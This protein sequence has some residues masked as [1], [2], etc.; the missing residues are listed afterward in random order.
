MGGFDSD[1]DSGRG[2]A[3]PA[4]GAAVAG[5]PVGSGGGQPGSV[6]PGIAPSA[7]I[8]LTPEDQRK[9]SV[10]TEILTTKNDND[11]RMDTELKNLSPAAKTAIQKKYQETVSEKRNERGTL[12]FVL[13]REIKDAS[14]LGFF[15]EVL[16]EKACL[17][18]ENCEKPPG[19]HSGEEEHLEAINETTANYPQLMAVR[20]LVHRANE[21]V[22]T[23][24][25]GSPLYQ[26]ILD[27]LKAAQ[28]SPNPKVV[29]LSAQALNDLKRE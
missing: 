7:A 4:T 11:P 1:F 20:A 17:S 10:L 8:A 15:K 22:D 21:L 12:V 6:Q 23:G 14:E 13:G 16:S 24:Q 5:A 9:I 25:E 3:P 2:T 29:E 26:S 28:Q 19:G 18:L 27:T